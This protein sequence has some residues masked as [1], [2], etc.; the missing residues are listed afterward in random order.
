MVIA[1]VIC[2]SNAVEIS[3]VHG[4]RIYLVNVK[5]T[6]YNANKIRKAIIRQNRPMASDKAN[7]RIVNENICCFNEGFLQSNQTITHQLV[8]HK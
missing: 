6:D 5:S 2:H 4:L 1:G 8:L 3:V 7:P